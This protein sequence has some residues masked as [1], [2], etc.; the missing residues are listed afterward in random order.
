M[1]PPPPPPVPPAVHP[2]PTVAAADR[3]H[4]P[5]E[6]FEWRLGAYWLGRIGIVVLLTGLVF[7]GNFVWTK[8]IQ[9]FGPWGKLSVYALCGAALGMLGLRL[10]ARSESLRNFGR[11]L[12]AGGMALGYYSVYAAH[13]VERLRDVRSPVL[14]GV[15]LLAAAGLL[16]R[17]ADR[18]RSQGTAMLTVLLAFYT[19]AMN[20]IAGFSLFSNA[21][22]CGAALFFLWRRQWTGLTWLSMAGSYAAFG[23]WRFHQSGVF[24]WGTGLAPDQFWTSRGFLLAYWLLFSAAFLNRRQAFGRRSAPAAL[25]PT[26]PPSSPTRLLRCTCCTRGRSG[27][28]RWSSARCCWECPA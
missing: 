20:P 1:R 4:Q 17:F 25:P 8:Y 12:L 13:F 18:R 21:L 11:V 5:A 3:P 15:L 2:V 27:S 7:L 14:G 24:V 23:F 9:N 22:L 19:G 26:T 10:E 16:V 28:F 6:A